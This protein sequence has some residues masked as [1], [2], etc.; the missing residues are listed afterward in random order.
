[1]Y[2]KLII[3]SNFN[4][5]N[6]NQCLYFLQLKKICNTYVNLNISEIFH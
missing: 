3:L 4:Y 6:I 2:V 1:M 5:Y